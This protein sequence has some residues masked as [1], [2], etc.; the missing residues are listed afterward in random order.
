ME[1]Y[2]QGDIVYFDFGSPYNNEIGGIRPA[3]IISADDYN[4]NSGYFMVVPITTH[5]TVFN[6]YV[7]LYHYQG[8]RGRVNVAQVRTY[9]RERIR[10]VVIDHL[11]MA[12]FKLVMG[13]L[14]DIFVNYAV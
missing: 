3:V 9:S 4:R 13:K 14:T 5:G 6:S 2:K 7:T 11:R 8:V 1:H 12:D 10:S